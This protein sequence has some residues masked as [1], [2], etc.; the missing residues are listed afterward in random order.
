MAV[1]HHGQQFDVGEKPVIL[2]ACINRHAGKPYYSVQTNYR[3]TR[4]DTSLVSDNCQANLLAT[5][6]SKGRCVPCTS[7]YLCSAGFTNNSDIMQQA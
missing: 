1:A 2:Y 4:K 6:D 3:L 7:T 5:T